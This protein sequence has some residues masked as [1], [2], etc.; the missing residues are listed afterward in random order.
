MISMILATDKNGG[1][2][3][4]NSLPWPHLSEDLKY[5]KNVT[6]NHVVVMGSNTW[7]SLGKMAPLP[8]RINYVITSQDHNL[9]EG[10]HDAYDYT[11][12]SMESILTAIQSRHPTQ[13]VFVVGGKKLYDEAYKFCEQ[14]HITQIEEEYETDT[15][16]DYKK[17]LENFSL[18]SGQQFEATDNTPAFVTQCWE[19]IKNG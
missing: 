15:K 1:I 10:T 13:T 18:L 14:I 11:K 17:Y 16:V 6:N 7:K 8:N 19:V 9:Y 12:Y 2:G 4:N 3:V 5:F